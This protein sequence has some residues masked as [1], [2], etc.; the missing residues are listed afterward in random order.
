[1]PTMDYS[2]LCGRIRE[3]GLNQKLVAKHVG[4]SESHFCLKLAGKYV[5]KQTEIQKIC[6]LL[7]ISADEIGTY[8][9]TPKVE[10]TQQID[11][12]EKHI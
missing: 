8:F 4:I 9:F 1:M 11:C 2:K 12:Q 7:R 3:V 10:K 6:E 5:F